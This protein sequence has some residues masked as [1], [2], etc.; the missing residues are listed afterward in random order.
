MFTAVFKFAIGDR[1]GFVGGESRADGTVSR[2][3]VAED[4]SNLI[5]VIHP[6]MGYDLIDGQLV[7]NGQLVNAPGFYPEGIL[8][9]AGSREEVHAAA[10]SAAAKTNGESAGGITQRL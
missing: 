7:P 8:R 10:E 6:G 1:V 4:G 5:E 3:M 9:H 2:L